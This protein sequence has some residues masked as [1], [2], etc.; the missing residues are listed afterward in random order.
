M[1]S[2]QGA[3]ATDFSRMVLVRLGASAP[4]LS[5]VIDDGPPSGPPG[6]SE[7]GQAEGRTSS[8][9]F[10]GSGPGGLQ[11]THSRGF[12]DMA[13]PHIH[14]LPPAMVT[15][16]PFSQEKTPLGACSVLVLPSC[17]LGLRVTP[18]ALCCILSPASLCMKNCLLASSRPW[19][20]VL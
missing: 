12:V 5:R 11:R 3:V 9:H 1:T 10:G 17:V 16:Q 4:P 19:L 8:R 15:R 2:G 7:W 6:T 18:V 14:H 13:C 20:A